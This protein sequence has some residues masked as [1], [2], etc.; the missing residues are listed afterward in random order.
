MAVYR[1]YQTAMLQQVPLTV[2]DSPAG[3]E[4]SLCVWHYTRVSVEGREGRVIA[5][6]RVSGRVVNSS[7][8]SH[9][10]WHWPLFHYLVGSQLTYLPLQSDWTPTTGKEKIYTHTHDIARTA[11]NIRR[12]Y[13]YRPTH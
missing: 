4:L 2:S 9:R 5:S 7:R 1:L 6:G 13:V 11:F 8:L 3:A 12:P 10:L